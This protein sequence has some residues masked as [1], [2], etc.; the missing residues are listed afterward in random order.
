MPPRRPTLL[1]FDVV[2]A[3]LPARRPRGPP[4]EPSAAPVNFPGCVASIRFEAA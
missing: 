2:V 1:A 3:P 4:P